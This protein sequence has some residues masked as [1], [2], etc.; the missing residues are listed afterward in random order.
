[1]EEIPK[2]SYEEVAR[3]DREKSRKRTL[4]LIDLKK[5]Y[6]LDQVVAH[7]NAEVERMG[8]VTEKEREE[9]RITSWN[10]TSKQL[11]EIQRLATEA[12]EKIE[13]YEEELAQLVKPFVP[14]SERD[15]TVIAQRKHVEKI[16]EDVGDRI[17][18]H[19]EMNQIPDMS[20]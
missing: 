2:K 14:G 15:T 8:G 1:M 9:Q 6:K 3:E 16:L 17:R 19:N 20:K 11:S 5:R 12:L 4:E 7:L 18:Q 13:G 10:I